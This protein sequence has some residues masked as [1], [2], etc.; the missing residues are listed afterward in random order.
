M[1]EWEE[2]LP[3]EEQIDLPLLKVLSLSGLPQLALFSPSFL[4]SGLEALVA[5]AAMLSSMYKHEL[6]LLFQCLTPLTHLALCGLGEED[7]LNTLLKELILPTSLWVLTLWC[8]NGLK[9][10]E[11]KGLQHLTSL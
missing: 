11:G 9:L 7:L 8:F 3:F 4:P 5:E 2:W 10:L 6:G 1:P